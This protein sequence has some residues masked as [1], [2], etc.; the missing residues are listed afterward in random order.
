MYKLVINKVIK[1]N[2]GSM[3]YTYTLHTRYPKLNE[4]IIISTKDSIHLNTSYPLSADELLLKV[5]E[6]TGKLDEYNNT[7]RY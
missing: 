3:V 5:L 2:N 4:D 6:R 1:K 7:L